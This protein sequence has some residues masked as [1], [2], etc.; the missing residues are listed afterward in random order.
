MGYD[1]QSTEISIFLY[2]RLRRV[3]GS[4][5]ALVKPHQERSL[6]HH[7]LHC[8]P[9]KSCR[10]PL[11]KW[12]LPNRSFLRNSW[13]TSPHMAG[14]HYRDQK[15]P[16]GKD[17]P[18]QKV[19][20]LLKRYRELPRDKVVS[21][22]DFCR[23]LLG[24]VWRTPVQKALPVQQPWFHQLPRPGVSVWPPADPLLEHLPGQQPQGSR[25]K[26]LLRAH[27]QVRNTSSPRALKRPRQRSCR[28]CG[29]T[30]LSKPQR[31][32]RMQL[33]LLQKNPLPLLHVVFLRRAHLGN[34][35]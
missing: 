33:W 11:R 19:P 16:L 23:I 7:R 25:N 12:P 31:D 2:R 6:G 13:K 4:L 3:T 14:I 29:I 1:V 26:P 30:K 15:S 32:Q 21:P 27:L 18:W 17:T 9:R 35:P 24:H 8:A 28:S 10:N 20:L 5:Q 34:F 22:P